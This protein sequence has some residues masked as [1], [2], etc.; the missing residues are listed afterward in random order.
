MSSKTARAG[1]TKQHRQLRNILT[2]DFPPS[3]D[4]PS[5]GS[6]EVQGQP[7]FPTPRCWPQ[8][9]QD[10]GSIER[11]CC[12]RYFPQRNNMNLATDSQLPATEKPVRED[13]RS[14]NRIPIQLTTP[15][16]P[17]TGPGSSTM[18]ELTPDTRQS[19]ES[20]ESTS[21]SNIPVTRPDPL[22]P[23]YWDSYVHTTNGGPTSVFLDIPSDTPRCEQSRRSSPV[24]D[25]SATQP[26]SPGSSALESCMSSYTELNSPTHPGP[27]AE[28]F[29]TSRTSVLPIHEAGSPWAAFDVRQ[30]R[31]KTRCSTSPP[32]ALGDM[33]LPPLALDIGISCM[34]HQDEI[35]MSSSSTESPDTD[36]DDEYASC[37]TN[38]ATPTPPFKAPKASFLRSLNR[39]MTLIHKLHDVSLL[40]AADEPTDPQRWRP[41]HAMMMFTCCW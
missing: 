16:P 12:A 23:Y 8:E 21:S 20:G 38:K 5:H 15:Q 25:L 29:P 31:R 26:T 40:V 35:S 27:E 34:G 37:A 3:N 28:F 4:T 1:T 7:R 30:Q 32:E 18:P 17:S 14:T 2:D 24:P 6:S 39:Y 41:R 10:L 19:A 22:A 9:L 13:Y 36:N 11:C 33:I